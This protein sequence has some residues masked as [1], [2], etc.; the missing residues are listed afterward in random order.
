MRT[1][2]DLLAF[3]PV[4]LREAEDG[5]SLIALVDSWL[6]ND[7]SQDYPVILVD[8][9]AKYWSRQRFQLALKIANTTVRPSCDASHYL[10]NCK[11]S[12]C[13][14]G[15]EQFRADRYSDIAER[16]P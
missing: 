3:R 11:Q 2:R 5:S 1:Q 16:L 12:R 10:E 6:G 7:L 4:R 13:L 8:V 14:A 9:E 15:R